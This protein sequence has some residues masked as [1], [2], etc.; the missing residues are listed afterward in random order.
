MCFCLNSVLVDQ[1]SG[2]IICHNEPE[3]HLYL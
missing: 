2:S 3:I 1:F